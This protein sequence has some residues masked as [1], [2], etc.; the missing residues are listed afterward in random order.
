[1]HFDGVLFHLGGRFLNFV[2]LIDAF[3]ASFSAYSGFSP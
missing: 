1:M 2:G 3:S